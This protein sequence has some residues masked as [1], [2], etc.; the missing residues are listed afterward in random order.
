MLGTFKRIKVTLHDARGRPMDQTELVVKTL[1]Q[2]M[3][4]FLQLNVLLDGEEEVG[5]VFESLHRDEGC[6]SAE[7]TLIDEHFL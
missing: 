3:L 2:R 4:V 1:F 5:D 6:D 7:V